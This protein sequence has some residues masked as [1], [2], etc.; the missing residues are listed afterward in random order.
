MLFAVFNI[1]IYIYIQG[2]QQTLL[3]K[4]TY[5]KYICRKKEKQEYVSVG[6]VRMFIEPSAKH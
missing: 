2:I 5:S 4:A 6:T 1:Y 3:S